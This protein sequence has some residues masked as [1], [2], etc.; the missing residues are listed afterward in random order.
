[1]IE[2]ED[3]GD[4]DDFNRARIEERGDVEEV[5]VRPGRASRAK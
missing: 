5:A 1:L 4:A 2:S 3:S